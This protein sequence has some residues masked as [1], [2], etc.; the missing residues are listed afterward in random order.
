MVSLR[1]LGK[2]DRG[3]IRVDSSGDGQMEGLSSHGERDHINHLN[4]RNG[5]RGL[6]FWAWYAGGDYLAL[7][8]AKIGTQS[9]L[10][11]LHPCH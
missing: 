5:G 1:S 4:G 3:R 6:E 7:M 11:A 8:K 9:A 10:P 2:L